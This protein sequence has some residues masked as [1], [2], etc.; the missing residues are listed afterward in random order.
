VLAAL[1]RVVREIASEHLPQDTRLAAGE[2]EHAD[3]KQIIA[4]HVHEVAPADDARGRRDVR[5]HAVVGRL[6]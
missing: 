2:F 3:L 4:N 1:R 5:R 6:A